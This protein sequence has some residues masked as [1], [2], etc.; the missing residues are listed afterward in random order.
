MNNRG[1][2]IQTSLEEKGR[3]WVRRIGAGFIV[4]LFGFSLIAYGFLGVVYYQMFD[5]G[6]PYL[7]NGGK[8]SCLPI[9]MNPLL[10]LVLGFMIVLFLLL[11]KQ[12]EL[13]HK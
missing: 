5:R 13:T 10:F 12:A 9:Y 8:Y 4:G 3:R 1:W 6:I 2:E 7:I 11:E